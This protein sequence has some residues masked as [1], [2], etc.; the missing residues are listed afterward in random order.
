MAGREAV[1][2]PEQFG[3]LGIQ[4]LAARPAAKRI[5]GTLVGA[6]RT[7]DAEVD[8]AWE[9]ALQRRPTLGHH[10]RRVVW[11]HDTARADPNPPRDRRSARRQHLR[12]R[13]TYA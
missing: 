10:K 3:Q 8:P 13:A 11:Q 4:I 5:G 6:R 1:Q 2:M 7:A 9:E 12:C